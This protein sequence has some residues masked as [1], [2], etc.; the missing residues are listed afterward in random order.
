MVDLIWKMG[1]QAGEGAMV[2]GRTLG[3]T[4]TRGGLNVIGYPEYPSLIRGG[5]NTYQIRVSDA[6]INSPLQKIDV[7]VALNKEGVYFHHANLKD[8]GAL[9]YDE[10]IDISKYPIRADIRKCPMPFS[11]IVAELKALP[12]MKNTIAL[13]ATLALIDYPFEKLESVLADEFRRKGD[14]IIKQNIS[15]AKAGY[16]HAK[17]HF[18]CGTFKVKVKPV[19]DKRKILIG[20]NE[21]VGMGAIKAGLKLFASYPMTPASTLMHYIAEKEHEFGIVMKHTEDEIA[22]MNYTVGAGFAGVRAMCS[23]SGGGFSLKVEAIGL[24]AE[25]ES[26]V[27]VYLAQR[28]GPS[29]GMPTWTEQADLRFAVHAS[30]GEFLRVILAPGDV[31]ESFALAWKAFNIAEKYQIPVIIMS[32]KFL[33]ESHFSTDRFDESQVRIERGKI[34]KNLKPLP[35]GGRFKRY[36][37]TKDGVSPRPLPG[38]PNG[39]HVSSSYE[40]DETGFSSENFQM[41]AKMVDKRARKIKQLLAEDIE[42]PTIHGESMPQSDITIIC[43]GSQKLPALDSLPIL[44]ANGIKANVIHFG[45][46]YPLDAKKVKTLLKSANR[47]VVVENNSTGQFAGILREYVGF[48]PNF[49][50][51]KYDGRQFFPEQIAEEVKKLH[52]AG[53]KGKREIRVVEKEDVEYYYPGHYQI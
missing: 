44:K 13:G 43:W 37:L 49:K 29:T 19:S 48:K 39:M 18:D 3:K 45:F 47:T 5:H 11:K 28:V 23:T 46:V 4:F 53:W 2:T 36:L 21:A 9:V 20:G 52:D 42:P 51:L 8:G 7:V 15:V 35:Q 1:G 50:M 12:Q 41:R 10:A 27:V 14:E 22:A 31:N 34:A 33:G 38:E 26:P 17:A 40:H 32:D 25:S 30:Q 16:D 24:A 6:A